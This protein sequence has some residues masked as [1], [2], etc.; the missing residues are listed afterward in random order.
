MPE[1]MVKLQ[2]KPTKSH[3]NHLDDWNHFTQDEQV[4][5][6]PESVAKEKLADF[7][8]NFKI[9]REQNAPEKKAKPVVAPVE[10]QPD[11]MDKGEKTKIKS[12]K[13]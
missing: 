1:K 9:Y 11:K 7:P 12:Y 10:E 3:R 8:L 13:R 2:F 6:Y 4:G 5:E